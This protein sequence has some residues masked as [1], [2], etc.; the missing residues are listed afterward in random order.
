VRPAVVAGGA[1]G[2]DV[3]LAAALE[4]LVTSEDADAVVDDAEDVAV[5]DALFEVGDESADVL[6][7]AVGD[8]VSGPYS[9]IR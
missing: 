1:S 4:L 6:A 7:D 8:A 9:T 5:C 2:V 3:A